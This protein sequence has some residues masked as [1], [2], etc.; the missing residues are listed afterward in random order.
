MH[1]SSNPRRVLPPPQFTLRTLLLLIT[2][3]AA[4]FALVNLVHPLV[5]CGLALLAILVA[6]H[7]AG[8]VIGT[9]LREIG[10]Q[11]ASND[12][13]AISA[14][15]RDRKVDRGSFAPPS[16][17]ARK[18]SLGL[19]VLIVTAAGVLVGGMGGGVWGFVSAG[20][21][22]W[23]NITVGSVA[24]GFLGGFAS[25]AVYSFTQVLM[26]AWTQAARPPSPLHQSENDARYPL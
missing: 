3:F 10:D 15:S 7:V 24:V 19:P 18:S 20:S 25:F 8:N 22:G 4:F 14:R 1:P 13:E 23:L 11:P 12:G 21:E 26:G 16:D 17:L 6:A 2:L 9:R 5:I